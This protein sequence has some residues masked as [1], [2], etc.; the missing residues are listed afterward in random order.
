MNRFAPY[1]FLRFTPAFILGI[2]LFHYTDGFRY[3]SWWVLVV[4]V[5]I[6]AYLAVKDSHRFRYLNGFL[7]IMILVLL[8]Y[9]RLMSFR[10]DLRENHLV[11]HDGEVQFY[12]AVVADE[13]RE[14]NK[15]TQLKLKVLEVYSPNPEKSEG[16]VLGYVRKAAGKNLAYGDI[17]LIRG[18][19]S[20]VAPPH[21]PGEFDYKQYL[22]FQQIF[23]Q[24]FIGEDFKVI[25]EA[26]P[27]LVYEKSLALRQWCRK[28]IH[29]YLPESE[30]RGIV[31]ALVLGV[32]EELDDK[33]RQ[34][35]ASAG[36]M[37][38]L[39]V[40][41]LHVGIIYGLILLFFK[42]LPFTGARARWLL[43]V[44]SILVL[45]AYAFVTGLSPSVLRAVTMF[46][47]VALGK[48][49]DRN[50]NIY[51][52]LA[53]SAFV[54]LW[55]NPYLIMS[56]GFQLSYLAVFG[57][58]YLQPKFYH[59]FEVNNVLLDRI[60]AI[61][62]VSLAAQI[63][64]APLSIVY[65]HQ[66]PT[67][68]LIA[69]LFVIPAAFIILILGLALLLLSSVPVLGD[70]L[71]TVLDFFVSTTNQFIFAIE[72]I[73]GSV[74]TG[75][76]WAGAGSWFIYLSITFLLLLFY[77]RKFKFLLW[78]MGMVMLFVLNQ[79][80]ETTHYVKQNSIRFFKISNA[81]VMDLK[82]GMT[83]V[84]ITDSLTRSDPKK[85]QFHVVPL[86][87]KQNLNTDFSL[88]RLKPV[89]QALGKNLLYVFHNC[90]MFWVKEPLDRNLRLK[91]KLP[92]D[93]V[94]VS[95][96]AVRDLEGLTDILDFKEL[97][98]DSS[99]KKYR[100]EKLVE[101]AKKLNLSV[102]AVHQ[103]GFLEKQLTE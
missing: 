83:S 1:P 52:T 54:L 77:Y 18:T 88:D 17:L 48:A 73:P 98:I 5:A 57:I 19:P 33:T 97:V 55:Y 24:H 34:A 78:S 95:R 36:A 25:G 60:W 101:Q 23:H 84:L 49:L 70:L 68:F 59:L 56:V 14:K 22:F 79:V 93:M 99:N 7:A 11:N 58:V 86:R 26:S 13:P 103:D 40:S 15:A 30:T 74:I 61:T 90:S 39:A 65:F 82:S 42:Q 81:P 9:F 20:E 45:W 72:S 43:A 80:L 47:F 12:K 89:H 35:Y 62:C 87:L 3:V 21:N 44:T 63:A 69:N 64:T 75:I 76:H 6:Y 27:S 41:G 50:T 38:V 92:I 29:K 32:K 71:G 100:S 102:H 31:L 10:Q 53:A 94:I 37:H 8:G 2:I 4:P 28:T 67:Y 96:N 66:F 51:N 46:S 85:L 91:E 16:Y